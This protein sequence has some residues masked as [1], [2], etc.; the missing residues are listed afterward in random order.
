MGE[1]KKLKQRPKHPLKVHVWAGISARGATPIVIFTGTLVATRLLSIFELGLVPFV[2][3]V[4]P[5]HHRLMQDNDPKHAS[6]LAKAFLEDEGIIWW[7]T[8]PES[9]DLNLIENV[10]GSM[11]CFLRDVHKPTNLESL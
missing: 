9:P 6:N 7:K 5:D 3:E 1:A 2:R 11:K 8:P 4:F 10:W